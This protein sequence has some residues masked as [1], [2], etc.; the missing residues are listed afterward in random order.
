[1]VD[2]SPTLLH[3]VLG[4]S[5]HTFIHTPDLATLTPFTDL[6]SRLHPA[7]ETQFISRTRPMSC[8]PRYGVQIGCL[9]T[10]VCLVSSTGGD[11]GF[12]SPTIE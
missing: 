2:R 6:F 4:Q 9:Y 12:L 5:D 1:M 11:T 10:W 3:R 7:E 8:Q